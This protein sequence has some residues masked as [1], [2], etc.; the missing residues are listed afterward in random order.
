MG[1]E[2]R[3]G[4]SSREAASR[5]IAELRREIER[6]NRLYYVEARPEIDDRTYDALYKE[7]ADLE[8]AW[9]DLVSPDSPTQR[10]GGAPLKGFAPVRHAIPMMSLANSYNIA[11]VRNFD[12]RVRELA[13]PHPLSYVVEPKIDGVAVSARY[14]NGR[15]VLGAT[16]GDGQTGDDITSNLKTIRSLPLRLDGVAP[17]VVE[18]RGEV[19]MPKDGFRRLNEEREEAGEEPF[20]NPRNAAAGTLKQLDP[21]IVAKRPLS[22]VFYGVGEYRG[23]QFATHVELIQRMRTWGLPTPPCYWVCPDMTAIERALEELRNHRY[24]FPFEMDGAVIK[25]NDRSLYDTLGATAK[26]PRWAVAFKYEPDRA[27]TVLRAISIQVGRTGVLTPVAELEPVILAGSTITRATLHNEQEIHRKDIR[28]GDRVFVEKAG[29]V[30]PAVVS[31]NIAARTGQ[32][33]P[34]HMPLVCPVCGEPV[35][36]REGEVAVRCENLQCPAQLKR[37]LRH[38]ASRGAMDIEGLGEAV[39]DQLVDRGM[40]TSPAD[41]Y[42]LRAVDVATLERLGRKSAANLEAAIAASRDRDFWRVIYAM[43]I[44]HVGARSAQMLEEHFSRMEDLQRA[45]VEELTALPEIG[46]VIA[47]S[48]RD[49]F[50]KERNRAFLKRLAETG[51]TMQRRETSFAGSQ[52]LKGRQFVLT[53][54]LATLTREEAAERI[55]ALGGVV[56]SAVSKKTHYVVAGVSPG[57]KLE[58]AR[59]LGVSVLD[60]NTFLQMIGMRTHES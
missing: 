30:I 28:I 37:W 5:R 12:R 17:P 2:P 25:V 23:I 29:D 43:G 38:Y 35:G 50:D 46:P 33:R 21:S 54:T 41:L 42:T 15:F 34:F 60:E 4:A 36:R 8:S 57:S 14:E 40:V 3:T 59:N 26:S 10:V 51:V 13:G 45:T 9:P 18:V 20:A 47:T 31:V 44:R 53:G 48:I 22:I 19:Y 6:H 16:R 39:I 49:W 55:R 1:N 27:E 7:L 32:E 56:A 11:E 52:P 24:E 58:R